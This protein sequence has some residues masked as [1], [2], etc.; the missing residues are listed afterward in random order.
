MGD[1][2][3]LRQERKR[4]EQAERRRQAAG[5]RAASGRTKTDRQRSTAEH[6]QLERALDN[7]HLDETEPH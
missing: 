2:I 4:R 7:H 1:V 6:D 3:N 5:R